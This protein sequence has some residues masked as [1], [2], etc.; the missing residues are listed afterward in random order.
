MCTHMPLAY[1]HMR[2]QRRSLARPQSYAAGMTS[3]PPRTV[4]SHTTTT[5]TYEGSGARSSQRVVKFD[6]AAAAKPRRPTS[7][8]MKVFSRARCWATSSAR[9]P[10]LTGTR[11]AKKAAVLAGTR[12]PLDFRWFVGR[13][14]DLST[15]DGAWRSIACARPVALKQCLGL[16]KP[17]WHE[18]LELCGGELSELSRIEILKREDVEEG[19]YDGD[20]R[21]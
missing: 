7:S 18:V 4:V 6:E 11:S 17:L 5:T 8:R 12:R 3:P 10:G 19:D 15:A 2:M 13:R 20:K 1:T 14:S 9:G 21:D 16:P